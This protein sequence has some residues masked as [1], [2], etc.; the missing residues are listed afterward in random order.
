MKARLL[1]QSRGGEE[2][3]PVEVELEPAGGFVV[4]H[5]GGELAGSLERLPTGEGLLRIGERTVPFHAVRVG[6]EL[7][8]W[9]DGEVYYFSEAAARGS[10]LAESAAASGEVRAPMPG[11]VV[12]VPARAGARVAAGDLLA[13]IESM[14]VQYNLTAPAAA[15][16]TEVLGEPGRMVELDAVLVRLEPEE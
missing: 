9:L 4:R 2:A 13:V 10:E 14:K 7:H 6:R 16:V 3:F 5:A 11:R 15:T 1:L 12:Q 8:L